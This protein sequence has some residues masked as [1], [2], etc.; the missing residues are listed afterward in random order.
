MDFVKK[1][2]D[3]GVV[4]ECL[5]VDDHREQYDHDDLS[6]SPTEQYG[7]GASCFCD[8]PDYTNQ[9]WPKLHHGYKNLVAS[10]KEEILALDLSKFK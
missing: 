9:K 3:Q 6:L 2:S 10:G 4:V 7:L 1:I 8:E 5:C